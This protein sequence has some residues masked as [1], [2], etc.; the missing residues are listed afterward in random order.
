MDE[1]R[2][3]W[4]LLW[5]L[6]ALICYLLARRALRTGKAAG[7]AGGEV[8]RTQASYYLSLL[9]YAFAGLAAL[10]LALIQFHRSYGRNWLFA[11]LVLLALAA[12][13]VYRIR[14]RPPKPAQWLKSRL[15]PPVP[16]AAQQAPKSPAAAPPAWPEAALALQAAVRGFCFPAGFPLPSPREESAALRALRKDWDIEDEESFEQTVE[17]LFEEGHRREFHELIDR[18]SALS[19]E[20]A[21]AYRVEI[22][23]GLY[24]LDTEAEQAEELARVEMI[25]SNEDGIRYASF[26]AWDFLRLLDLYRLGFLAGFI[27][28]KEAQARMLAACQV[29]QSRYDSWEEMGRQFLLARRF[30]SA[31]E[32]QRDEAAWERAYQQLR[33]QEDSLWKRVAWQQNL[34]GKG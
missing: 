21:E 6:A 15:A 30:W 28:G 4:I 27:E 20:E 2:P 14:R 5:L 18:V 3:E 32:M 7:I 13:G 11:A 33:L 29:L 25:R 22:A 34:Q 26:I 17:W 9:A 1:K 10:A 16:A 31:L 12:W 24:G 8:G 19:E 23:E